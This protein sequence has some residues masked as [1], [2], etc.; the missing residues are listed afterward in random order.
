MGT[1]GKQ[2]LSVGENALGINKNMEENKGFK[3]KGSSLYGKLNLNRGGQ[4]NMVDGRPGSS[5]LQHAKSDDKVHMELWGDKHTN[6]AHPDHWEEKKIDKEDTVQNTQSYEGTIEEQKLKK[7]KNE[8]KSPLDKKTPGEKFK[9]KV[10]KS[11]LVKDIKKAS[12]IVGGDLLKLQGYKNIDPNGTLHPNQQKG[13]ISKLIPGTSP[14]HKYL[15]KE[16]KDNFLKSQNES[17]VKRS[18]LDKKGKAIW[19]KN[20]KD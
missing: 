3:M 5:A 18:D 13:H 8:D 17:K 11:K 20:N 2:R 10:S 4:N 6:K 19:D 12:S 14:Q 16:K 1:R 7:K 9:N 15:Y